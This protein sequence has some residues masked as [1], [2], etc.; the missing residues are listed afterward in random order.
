MNQTGARW[1]AEYRREVA[2]EARF[3]RPV[4]HD[5]P[6]PVVRDDPPGLFALKGRLNNETLTELALMYRTLPRAERAA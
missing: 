5:L 3:Q 6:V 2:T 1:L 4:V